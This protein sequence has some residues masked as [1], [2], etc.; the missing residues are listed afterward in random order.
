MTTLN[1][2]TI[3]EALKLTYHKVKKNHNGK[4]ADYIPYLKNANSNIYGITIVTTAGKIYEIGDTTTKIAIESIAKVFTLCLALEEHSKE[5]IMDKIGVSQSFLPFNSILGS[6]IM[7]EYHASTINPFVNAGAIATTSLITGINKYDNWM[8]LYNNMNKFAGRRLEINEKLYLSEKQTN[9]TNNALAHLL[10]SHKRFYGN[11]EDTLEIYTRQGSIMVSSTELAVMASTL[12]NCGRNPFTNEQI[13]SSEHAS[14][15]LATMMSS[16]LYNYSGPWICNI[17]LPG[18]SGVGGGIIAVVPGKLAIGVVSP[19]LDSHGNS[20]RG[21]ETC[22]ELSK[23]LNL[24]LFNTPTSC[25]MSKR[26]IH[27]T[28][29][30]KRQKLNIKSKKVKYKI[31]PSLFKTSINKQQD[32]HKINTK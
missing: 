21:I 16:G 7:N 25:N 11:I 4:N 28:K 13:V 1:S 27:L 23:V 8:K 9:K 31:D 30:L 15:V 2:K 10:D 3:T 14:F 19:K 32:I 20:V 22:I 17:G 29:R 26:K 18:K 6:E 24:G 12:A 5:T